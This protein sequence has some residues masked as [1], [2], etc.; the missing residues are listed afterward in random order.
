MYMHKQTCTFHIPN[1]SCFV[2]RHGGKQV[3]TDF[4]VVSNAQPSC[5]THAQSVPTRDDIMTFPSNTID[6]NN[7]EKE[8]TIILA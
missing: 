4:I 5:H 7:R 6:H 3:T 8:T 2:F 1:R